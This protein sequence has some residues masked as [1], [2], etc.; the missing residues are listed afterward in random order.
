MI[1]VNSCNKYTL[2]TLNN[3]FCL[4]SY[5]LIRGLIFL[6]MGTGLP[7]MS[8]ESSDQ[9]LNQP[10]EEVFNNHASAE[11]LRLAH[12]QFSS[13]SSNQA[14]KVASSQGSNQASNQPLNQVSNQAPEEFFDE[15][16]KEASNDDRD[17]NQNQTPPNQSQE[18]DT[19]KKK[20]LKEV[21]ESV[22]C[23][24]SELQ[25]FPG[26]CHLF[27]QCSHGRP[28]VVKCPSGTQYH[29][30]GYCNWPELVPDCD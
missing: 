19:E 4:H 29:K 23:K 25:P 20:K 2:T 24:G 22:K 10:S 26:D 6:S 17:Q 12:K 15:T 9:L 5:I 8:G 30:D 13:P 3:I 27:I 11:D 1:F 18:K 21:P 28:S 7:S 16:P 14:S